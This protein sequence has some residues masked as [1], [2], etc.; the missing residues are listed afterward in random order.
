[1]AQTWMQPV[2]AG[3][4][5]DGSEEFGRGA[6]RVDVE[7]SSRLEPCEGLRTGLIT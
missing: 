3:R 7:V 1:M 5:S 6:T 4:D 2:A